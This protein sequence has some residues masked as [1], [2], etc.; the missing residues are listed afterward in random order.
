MA[1]FMTDQSKGWEFFDALFNGAEQLE[2][3]G[4]SFLKA[5]ATRAGFDFKKLKTDAGSLK[6]QE[7]LD[8]D[9][10]E[11]DKIGVSGTPYF[12][13]NDLVVRGAVSKDLFEDA[14]EMALRLS[15][16]QPGRH[17]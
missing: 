14:I 12:L 3:D 6:I 7:R 4:E 11:A 13:V 16:T 9:R 2:R 8:A 17:P 5:A 1:A 15:K 10:S